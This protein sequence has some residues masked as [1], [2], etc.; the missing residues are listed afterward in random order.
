MQVGLVNRSR[1]GCCILLYTVILY[2]SWQQSFC[3][4]ITAGSRGNLPAVCTSMY[5]TVVSLP[6]LILKPAFLTSNLYQRVSF[7]S[8]CGWCHATVPKPTISNRVY[9]ITYM[10]AHAHMYSHAPA[11][12]VLYKI[13][14]TAICLI[15]ASAQRIHR[16][17]W[18]SD[19]VLWL[20][21]IKWI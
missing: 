9:V 5:M 17:S 16:D 21:R 8:A 1:M 18:N 19:W 6:M 4:W 13:Q 15:I 11:S 10:P 7:C 12:S 2:S 20:S 14:K 3:R